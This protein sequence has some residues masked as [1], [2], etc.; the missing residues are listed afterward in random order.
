VNG[1][2]ATAIASAL[3]EASTVLL[4]A[5]FWSEITTWC[6]VMDPIVNLLYAAETDGASVSKLQYLLFQVGIQAAV[7][8]VYEGYTSCSTCCV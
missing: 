6:D 2:L 7:L 1:R 8:A 5:S 3:R 4:D